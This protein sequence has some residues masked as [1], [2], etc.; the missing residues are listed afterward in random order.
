VLVRHQCSVQ[1]NKKQ[2]REYGEEEKKRVRMLLRLE[3]KN[4]QNILQPVLQPALQQ[5]ALQPVFQPVL[6]PNI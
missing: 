1:K 6:Q 2:L 4:R 5:P 3:K